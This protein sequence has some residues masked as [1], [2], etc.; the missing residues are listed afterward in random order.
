MLPDSVNSPC[1]RCL[2][3]MLLPAG[4]GL[5]CLS[6]TRPSYAM[7]LGC[8]PAHESMALVRSHCPA[9]T[10]QFLSHTDGYL[11]F[12]RTS[13]WPG[14]EMSKIGCTTWSKRSTPQC[15]LGLIPTSGWSNRSSQV[16][17]PIA[18]LL[19]LLCSFQLSWMRTQSLD[20]R[21]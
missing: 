13:H 19:L 16:L 20:G 15:E 12:I 14:P 8:Q 10:S 17:I 1:S 2:A 4:A 7:L 6:R 5:L 11:G 3:T 18:N 9:V 21:F